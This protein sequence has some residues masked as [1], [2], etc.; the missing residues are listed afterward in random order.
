MP[1]PTSLSTRQA[2][3]IGTEGDTAMLCVMALE[4]LALAP[5]DDQ[6]LVTGTTGGV[7][8]AVLSRLGCH[9]VASTGPATETGYLKALEAADVI[10]RAPLSAPGK[11][12]QKERWTG[13]VDAVGSHTLANACAQTRYVGA[14]AA[15]GLA[16]R[17]DFPS[18]VASFILRGVRLIGIDSVMCPQANR[19]AAWARL[20]DDLDLTKLEAMTTDIGLADA[21]TAAAQILAGHVRG[22]FVVGVA[23]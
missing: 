13:V 14:V 12:L 23:C 5:G 8:I 21:V 19:R 11:P 18:S 15:C 16:Q 10:D 17:R 9:V 20:A 2:M 6:V 1:L 3:A 7:A 22:G 4:A